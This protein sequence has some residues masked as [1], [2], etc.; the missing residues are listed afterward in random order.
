MT[1]IGKIAVMLNKETDSKMTGIEQTA[2]KATPANSQ[3]FPIE[4]ENIVF[5]REFVDL[6]A[7]CEFNELILQNLMQGFMFVS[8]DLSILKWNSELELI[9]EI[10]AVKSI[11]RN[12]LEV[13]SELQ[14]D[15]SRLELLPRFTINAQEIVSTG[16]ST[17][18]NTRRKYRIRTQSG[19][20]KVV[21]AYSYVVERDGKFPF[22]TIIRDVSEEYKQTRMMMEDERKFLNIFANSPVAIAIVDLSNHTIYEVNRAFCKL[23]GWQA[24]EIIGKSSS[25]F[26]F[27]HDTISKKNYYEQLLIKHSIDDYQAIFNSKDNRE[28]ICQISGCL[29]DINGRECVIH[30]ISD[31]TDRINEELRQNQ[32][33][34]ELEEKVNFRNIELEQINDDLQVQI[35]EREKSELALR[36]SEENYRSLINQIPVGIYRTTL[37][38]EFLQA[39]PALARIF[40][41]DSVEDIMKINAKD[42][43]ANPEQRD[44]LFYEDKYLGDIFKEEIKVKRKDNSY[45]WINDFAQITPDD[46]HRSIIDGVIQDITDQKIAQSALRRSEEKYRKLFEN[47]TDI[48]I[49]FN[50]DG[51][52][53]NLSPSFEKMS[54]L[55]IPDYMYKGI[56]HILDNDQINSEFI[57][58]YPKLSGAA[59]FTVIFKQLTRKK[60]YYALNLQALRNA[61]DKVYA[62][63][64]IARDITTEITHNKVTQT[65]YDISRA[66]N[67]ADSLDDLYAYIH[68]ALGNII[69]T[70]NFFIAVLD[71]NN[72]NMICFPYLVDEMD[73]PIESIPLDTPDSYTALVINEKKPMLR[74][75]EEVERKAKD[76]A[77]GTY[78]Q[79][80]LGV[81]LQLKDKVI[82]AIVVQSYRDYYL[83]DEKDVQLLQS[84]SDQIALAIDRKNNQIAMDSQLKFVRNLIDTIPNAIY[85]KDVHSLKYKL[86]NRTYAESLGMQPKDLIGKTVFDI[87]PNEKA[88]IYN[89]YDKELLATQST[90]TYEETTIVLGKLFHVLIVRT[91][92][93]SIKGE[94]EGIVGVV[95]DITEQRKAAE[96]ISEALKK[97]IELN[98]LKSKF[99][100]M[101]SHEY[102]TPLQSIMLSTELLRDYSDKLNEESRMKQFDRIKN[103][104]VTLNS[105]LDD[106]LLLNKSERKNLKYNPAR[107]EICNMI[108][109]LV[110]EMQFVAKDKCELVLM[111]NGSSKSACLDEKLLHIVLT[112]VIGN[113]IK[114]S[115]NSK[116]VSIS[117]DILSDKVKFEIKDFGIGIP[118]E[119]HDLLY[120]P[121]FR[122]SNVGTISGTGLG[123]SI[124]KDAVSLQNGTI[125]FK[126][127]INVGTTFYI[128]IPYCLD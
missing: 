7:N 80:W 41:Y 127:E 31:I 69:D 84:V 122:S 74:R 108:Q 22:A 123:L 68:K 100:S 75:F 126:S 10:P 9:T 120:T 8:S 26:N 27:W 29:L 82:G 54:G 117:A 4:N 113:A 14:P 36:I 90:Q 3:E 124:V 96:T 95:L 128:E 97:E 5:N 98:E 99:I 28:I 6:T 114:Y 59:S 30:Y 37:S 110:R 53:T 92:L 23:F 81:P 112:N 71:K 62:Y 115:N 76:D 25:E 24:K 33:R 65:L 89:K 103:S 105:M 72:E 119:E 118:N 16:K 50:V 58:S 60:K 1:I 94:L 64:G 40:G 56:E 15:S 34:I 66:I 19:V 42:L 21:E 106:I 45:I 55:R 79:V 39:N 86:C 43:Y 73:E 70:T 116:L 12:L 109:S 107:M 17:L 111:I 93:F 77:T 104:I 88:Q 102:R 63:E 32:I 87:F 11:G 125:T 78:S 46:E 49:S 35:R 85:Y 20:D 121:F 67:T 48:Y 38:G 44:T 52:I 51:F 57:K 91:C 61:S 47:L 13:M 83:Y 101:V 2:N 18:L